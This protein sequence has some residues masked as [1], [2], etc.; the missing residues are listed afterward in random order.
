MYHIYKCY[1]CVC[2]VVVLF[3]VVS[4]SFAIMNKKKRKKEWFDGSCNDRNAIFQ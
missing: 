1:V 4:A 2:V 3:L